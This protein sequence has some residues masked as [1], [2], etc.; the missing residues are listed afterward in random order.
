MVLVSVGADWL[1]ELLV[2]LSVWQAMMPSISTSDV[3]VRRRIDMV[4]I[5]RCN[6]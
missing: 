5:S 2:V 3:R 6:N 1:V 4:W